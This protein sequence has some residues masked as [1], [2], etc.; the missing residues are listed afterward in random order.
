MKKNPEHFIGKRYSVGFCV[1]LHSVYANIN[2]CYNGGA[3]VV[4]SKS[5]NVSVIIVVQ[6]LLVNRQQVFVGAKN[7]INSSKLGLFL[8]KQVFNKRFQLC[9]S[10]QG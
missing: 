10:W 4:K 1:I 9:F 8:F 7:I 2:L 3:L 6:K 5:D